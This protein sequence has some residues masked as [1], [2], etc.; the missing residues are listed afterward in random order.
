MYWEAC[1]INSLDYLGIASKMPC[2]CVRVGLLTLE[3]LHGSTGR[4]LA[5]FAAKWRSCIMNWG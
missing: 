2:W 1:L 3:R 5:T 4:H